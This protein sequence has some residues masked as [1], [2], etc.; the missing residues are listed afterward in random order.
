M[1][2]PRAVRRRRSESG[3]INLLIHI[4][5]IVQSH[6]VSNYNSPTFF[7]PTTTFSFRLQNSTRISASL[8]GLSWIGA[9]V[10]ILA[11]LFNPTYLVYHVPR[12]RYNYHLEFPLHLADHEFLVQSVCPS[13]NEKSGS[14]DNQKPARQSLEPT[15]DK[16]D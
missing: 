7:T 14:S 9:S 11:S 4:A 13:K 5:H 1:R 3:K 16:T 6:I 12:I 10:G 8:V 15:Y 2:I